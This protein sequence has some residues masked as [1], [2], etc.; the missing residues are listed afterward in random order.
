MTVAAEH[1]DGRRLRKRRGKHRDSLFELLDHPD[2]APDDDGSMHVLRP[3]ATHG[4]L[5]GGSRSGRDVGIHAA[6]RSAIGTAARRGADGL[7]AIR[8]A[9]ALRIAS[10]SR[11]RWLF[12]FHRP[13]LPVDGRRAVDIAVATTALVVTSPVLLFACAVM[14]ATMHR[15]VFF[16]QQRYGQGGRIFTL[17]KLRSLKDVTNKDAV[18]HSEDRLT[19]V[20]RVI[21]RFGIDELPQFVNILKGDMSIFGP[22][23]FDVEPH[24]EGWNRRYDI[25]PGLIGLASVRE[26][27]SGIQSPLEKVVFDDLEYIRR[28]SWRMDAWLLVMAL[29]CIITGRIDPQE[30]EISN[31]GVYNTLSRLA[32]GTID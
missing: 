4:K 17:I 27:I 9:A 2:V 12:R 32:L 24:I 3:F 29:A 19:P 26:K 6:M 28:R 1:K 8:R 23:P 20:A 15:R 13:A 10:A 7:E 14:A 22:R 21:R 11:G 18:T 16:L 30:Q 25:K 5:T 31:G